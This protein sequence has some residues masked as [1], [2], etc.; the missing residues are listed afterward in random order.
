MGGGGGLGGDLPPQGLHGVDLLAVQED[1]EPD[2]VAVLLD[3]ACGR[4][5]GEG[6]GWA[7]PLM[8]SV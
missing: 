2:E 8:I 5:G 1:L 7:A 6:G 3:D 4:R